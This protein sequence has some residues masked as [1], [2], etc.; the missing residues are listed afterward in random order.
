MDWIYDSFFFLTISLC[1]CLLLFEFFYCFAKKTQ[2]MTYLSCLASALVC[3]LV[4]CCLWDEMKE[5]IAVAFIVFVIYFF[6][7]FFWKFVVSKALFG[8]ATFNNEKLMNLFF[9]N[10]QLFF[11]TPDFIFSCLMKDIIWQTKNEQRSKIVWCFNIENLV[12]SFMFII[13]FGMF[14]Y[15]DFF[16]CHWFHRI[17]LV[18]LGFRIISRTIEI[19]VSFVKDICSSEHSS[20]LNWQNRVTLAFLSIL[21]I[22]ILSFGVNYCVGTTHSLS[23][24]AIK[25]LTLVQSLPNV[26]L[27]GTYIV[28]SFSALC[29]FSLIGIVIGAYINGKKTT[30]AKA[31]EEAPQLFVM[32]ESGVRNTIAFGKSDEDGH[33]KLVLTNK[34][35]CSYVVNDR[36][37]YCHLSLKDY[38]N[39]PFVERAEIQENFVLKG[40]VFEIDFNENTKE[41]TISKEDKE[42]E[43]K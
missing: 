19:S 28:N 22:V 12:L 6:L 33:W 14:A 26:G 23:E 35:G 15:L 24:A 39:M 2:K 32:D 1:I 27:G 37:R 16:Q 41:I 43:E 42:N 8:P 29:C 10:F 11:V 25:A 3:I 4:V 40:E 30:R 38:E 18:F 34:L 31:I 13:L 36:G 20:K 9:L 21:E 5:N 17:V 7:V